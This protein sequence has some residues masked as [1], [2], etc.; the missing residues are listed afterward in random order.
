MAI[1]GDIQSLLATLVSGRC[2]P[3]VNTSTT[4]IKPYITYQVVS[5]VPTVSLD[6]PSGLENRRTQV[7][8]W[9]DT[10]GAA[11]ALEIAVKS[12]MQGA[13]FVN[14]PLLAQDFYEEETKLYRVSMDFSV[15]S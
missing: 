8:V 11:K 14:I 7:D 13:Y 3:L 6:G 12:A 15:W 2:Y 9:A 4:I 1:E 5:S 10:Y